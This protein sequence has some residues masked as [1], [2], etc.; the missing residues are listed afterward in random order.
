MTARKRT[1]C[2]VVAHGN[3]AE[4][5]LD[6]VQRI[7]GTQDGCLAVSNAGLGLSELVKTVKAAIDELSPT[8]DVVLFT[9]MPGGSCFHVC[10][11]IVVEREEIRAMSGVNLMMLLEF[12][13]KRDH[14]SIGDLL[15][16][17]EE[18]GRGAISLL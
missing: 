1:G 2:V 5:L 10:Q 13:V 14:H 18:R 6:G 11:E 3:L 16:L 12:F 8:H 9:D 17:V 7:L 4:C 15:R